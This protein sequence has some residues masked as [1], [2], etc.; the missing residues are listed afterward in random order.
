[1]EKKITQKRK[2]RFIGWWQHFPYVLSPWVRVHPVYRHILPTCMD[3]W[4]KAV[5]AHSLGTWKTPGESRGKTRHP[6]HCCIRYVFPGY[7]HAAHF[8]LHYENCVCM[9]AA[10]QCGLRTFGGSSDVSA[11][12][13]VMI[14]IINAARCICCD[15]ET[16]ACLS[17]RRDSNEGCAFRAQ[18]LLPQ[19]AAPGHI[20]SG[21]KCD[22][23]LFTLSLWTV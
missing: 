14:T 8:V 5:G 6:K 11:E 1:M 18:R 22:L 19:N 3:L 4:G 10:P 15:W 13:A 20:Y 12:A 2:P 9:K 17:L 21:I 16:R 23:I 7:H